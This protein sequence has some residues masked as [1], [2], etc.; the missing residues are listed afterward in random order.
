MAAIS[1]KRSIIHVSLQEFG[2]GSNVVSI[3]EIIHLFELRS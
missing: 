1:V 2:S 3:Y